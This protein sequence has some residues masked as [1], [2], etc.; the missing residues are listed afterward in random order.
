PFASCISAFNASASF[1]VHAPPN[2]RRG[3]T[4]NKPGRTRAINPP[5]ASRRNNSRSCARLN[6]NGSVRSP[7]RSV[8]SLRI[9][10]Y[11]SNIVSCRPSRVFIGVFYFTLMVLQATCEKYCAYHCWFT[12]FE[13]FHQFGGWQRSGKQTKRIHQSLYDP[14]KLKRLAE[15]C[16]VTQK[17]VRLQH[18]NPQCNPH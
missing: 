7:V 1:G 14:L 15:N 8:R 17:R 16:K 12:R 5:R 18:R 11:A 6:C 2:G 9:C 4:R 13:D 3:G 10:V